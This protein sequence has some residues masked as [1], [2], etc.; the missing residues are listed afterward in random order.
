M[1]KTC[2]ACEKKNDLIAELEET[3]TTLKSWVE[4][5]T[6]TDEEFEKGY[7]YEPVGKK[8]DEY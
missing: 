4:Y 6:M 7:E 1:S 5:T 3:I 2:K 8:G